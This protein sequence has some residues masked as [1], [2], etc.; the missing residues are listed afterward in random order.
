MDEPSDMSNE[1]AQCIGEHLGTV[2]VPA[3]K[4]SFIAMGTTFHVR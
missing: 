4:G 2:T 3:F 1:S